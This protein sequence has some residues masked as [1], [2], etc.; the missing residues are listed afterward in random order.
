MNKLSPRALEYLNAVA[1]FGSLR[2]AAAKLDVDPSAV[3]R[4]LSVLEEDVGL[5][6]NVRSHLCECTDIA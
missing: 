6:Y 1:R 2:K 3:S 5:L 4:M